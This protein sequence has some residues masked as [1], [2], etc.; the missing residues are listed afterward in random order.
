MPDNLEHSTSTL[1]KK[2]ALLLTKQASQELRKI[3]LAH[4]YT[5]FLMQLWQTDGQTQTELRKKIGIE[6][7]TAVRTLDR[8]Q[9]DGLILRKASS[10]D[11]RVSYIYL[12]QYAKNLEADVMACAQTINTLALKDF[13]SQDKK[14]INKLLI[15]IIKNLE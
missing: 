11:R 9:R 1:L 6:Q 4:A 2:A 12:T 10:S 13:S 14:T 8:M 3:D 5:P 7:P 15:T